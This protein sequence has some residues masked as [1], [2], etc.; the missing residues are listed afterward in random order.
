MPEEDRYMY[1][2][3]CLLFT[4]VEFSCT[5]FAFKAEYDNYG[6][7]YVHYTAYTGGQ[8]H[9]LYVIETYTTEDAK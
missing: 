5:V 8:L 6:P 1:I 7:H 9:S 3:L 2:K 4:R